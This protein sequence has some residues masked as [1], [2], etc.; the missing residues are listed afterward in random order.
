[1]IVE[2]RKM[3]VFS[4]I[5]FHLAFFH[6]K[7]TKQLSGST[8]LYVYVKAMRKSNETVIFFRKPKFSVL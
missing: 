2:M 8:R 6:I 3:P 4:N 7:P 5:S 1:V